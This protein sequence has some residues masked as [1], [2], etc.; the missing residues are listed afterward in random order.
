MHSTLCILPLVCSQSAL[1]AVGAV[2]GPDSTAHPHE[3]HATRC[4]LT[5]DENS[6]QEKPPEMILRVFWCNTNKYKYY[7]YYY[8][9]DSPEQYFL[10]L[11]GDCSIAKL[12]DGGSSLTHHLPIF[13]SGICGAITVY[14]KIIC[15]QCAVQCGRN[16]SVDGASHCK[17]FPKYKLWW[18]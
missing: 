18:I 14:R 11:P 6:A 9:Q 2:R 15:S 17:T 8:L 12:L 13:F 10:W 7:C 3:G 4:K 16:L 1:K 5:W